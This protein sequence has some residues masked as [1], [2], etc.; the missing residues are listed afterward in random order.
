MGIDPGHAERP[1]SL[2][3]VADRIFLFVSLKPP[4]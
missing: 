2:L 3:L 4:V 1:E